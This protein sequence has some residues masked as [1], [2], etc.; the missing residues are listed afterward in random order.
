M[1]LVAGTLYVMCNNVGTRPRRIIITTIIIII[2]I[3]SSSST[4]IVIIDTSSISPLTYHSS[5]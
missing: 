1:L 2:I 4:L 5:E 3:S